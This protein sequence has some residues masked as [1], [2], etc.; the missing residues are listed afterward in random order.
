MNPILEIV[1][2][3][4]EAE[5]WVLV[6]LVIFFALLFVFGVHKTAGK[7]IEGRREAIRSELDEAAKIRAE[8]QALLDSLKLKRVEAERHA[9]EMM[10]NAEAEALRYEQEARIKLEESLKR[11]EELAE[12]RI[13]QA[14]AQA[15]AEVKSA[16][17]D[18]AAALAEG[19]L[20]TRLKVKR[21]D[22]LIA[23]AVAQLADKLG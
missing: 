18:A 22:P 7:A 2:N 4:T 6:A 20:K 16:A 13:A 23:D 12:R 21:S 15:A 9:N 14:E 3:P 10:A 5:F 1:A 8:A 19:V 11:R 17:I